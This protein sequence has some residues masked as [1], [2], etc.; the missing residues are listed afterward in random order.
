MKMKRL[1]FLILVGITLGTTTTHATPRAQ[2]TTLNCTFT[3]AAAANATVRLR[4]GPGSGFPMVGT[5]QTG[6]S[7][8]VTGEDTGTD[9]FIWWQVGTDMWVRSDLG[10]S[11]CPAACGN[12]VCENGESSTSCAADCGAASTT[13]ESTTP[14][15]T[16]APVCL[17]D[18]CQSCYE[19]IDC[20]PD[21][22]EC[23]CSTD[24]SGCATCFCQFPQS[25]SSNTTAIGNSCE[26]ESC[27]ACI[28]AFPC[29]GG[30]CTK[31]ECS[32]NA[33]GCPVCSTGR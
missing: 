29:S 25:S 8:K 10:T 24:D 13:S 11:D 30:P 33:Y 14:A 23:E 21:C 6:D 32:L 28:A 22:S 26:F 19:S 3:A 20:Y 15:E 16:A 12:D 2:T 17:V 27:E 9:G 4:G 31:T 1:A 5:M 7:L 18:G